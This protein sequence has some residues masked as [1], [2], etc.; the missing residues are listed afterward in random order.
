M[1]E[2]LDPVTHEDPAYARGWNDALARDP[3]EPGT[4]HRYRIECER[5]GQLGT[6]RVSV[7]P[8]NAERKDEWLGDDR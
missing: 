4:A 2:L 6:L 1:S 3:C 5:C 7:D 8:E